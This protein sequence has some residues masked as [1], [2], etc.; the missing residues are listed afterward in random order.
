MSKNEIIG[1]CIGTRSNRGAK[2]SEYVL[3]LALLNLVEG[4]SVEG[5]DFLEEKL[6]LEKFGIRTP[7]RDV[8]TKMFLHT[9][10][11][12]PLKLLTFD[13]DD[14]GL[15]RGVFGSLFNCK[16][17]RGFWGLIR[18]CAEFELSVSTRSLTGTPLPAAN[19]WKSSSICSV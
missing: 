7:C 2:D 13:M 8:F 19:R 14:T 11:L 5:L 12:N 6:S 4:T 10:K 3:A 9:Q 15:K 16:E 17:N 18:Y 1:S